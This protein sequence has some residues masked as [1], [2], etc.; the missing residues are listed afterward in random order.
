MDA[1]EEIL[2]DAY[3]TSSSWFGQRGGQPSG[4]DGA[5]NDSSLEWK[6]WKS[7]TIIKQISTTSFSNIWF[8]DAKY[9]CWWPIAEYPNDLSYRSYGA[10]TH[11]CVTFQVV[12]FRIGARTKNHG[13]TR[14]AQVE[15]KNEG[16]LWMAHQDTGVHGNQH[17]STYRYGLKDLPNALNQCFMKAERVTLSQFCCK[18]CWCENGHVLSHR[19]ALIHWLNTSWWSFLLETPEWQQ[20]PDDFSVAAATSCRGFPKI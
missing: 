17:Y 9:W 10:N 1:L 5:E 16:S 12:I 2:W 3:R 19:V 8:C 11:F 20:K 15:A 18:I 6:C 7:P 4:V 13:G 14:I